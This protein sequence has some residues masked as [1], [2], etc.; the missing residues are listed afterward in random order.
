MK[1][2]QKFQLNLDSFLGIKAKLKQ[3][4]YIDWTKATNDEIPLAEWLNEK[5]KNVTWSQIIKWKNVGDIMVCCTDNSVFYE[6]D[7][8]DFNLGSQLRIINRKSW[9]EKKYVM[10]FLKSHLQKCLR[11]KR[12]IE[13]LRT[14]YEMMLININELLR[15]VCIIIFEDI[16][17]KNYFTTM[18]WLMAA[19]SKGYVLQSYQ[20]NLELKF[21]NDLCLEDR[22]TDLSE[23]KNYDNH[24]KTVDVRNLLLEIE[25]NEIITNQQKSLIYSI[26]L[27][28]GFGGREGDMQMIFDY[29]LIWYN[30]FQLYN[31][32]Q[33]EENNVGKI[34]IIKSKF[35]SIEFCQN[36]R[37]EKIEDFVNQGVDMNS[38]FKMVPEIYEEIGHRYSQEEIENAIWFLSSGWNVRKPPAYDQKMKFCWDEIKDIVIRKQLFFLKIML[39]KL[40]S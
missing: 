9:D 27:R 10:K 37:F 13:A 24:F 12:N 8:K 30:K 6:E 23:L 26:G 16:R 20:V 21:I 33:N 25:N 36:N 5:P 22:Y 1:K 35:V 31:K 29:S 39:S 4:F 17:L 7:S 40:Y 11:R 3:Y 2:K 19:V 38:Y 34:D 28:I 18:V 15:R 32:E 14:S